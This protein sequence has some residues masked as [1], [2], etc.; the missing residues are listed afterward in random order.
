MNFQE[1]VRA[2]GVVPV[3][4][5]DSEESAL[6]LG[7]ILM[8]EGL[9]IMELTFRNPAAAG[10]IRAVRK[11]FPGM[12]LGAGTLRSPGQ[13]DAALDAGADFLVSPS[14]VPSVMSAWVK[15]RDSVS[16]GDALSLPPYIPGV[17]TP[18]EVEEAL[19][20]GLSFLKFFPAAASGGVAMLKAMKATHPEVS[21]MPTGGIGKD[22]LPDFMA[23][24]NVAACGASAV[25]P[26]DALNAG[27]F[28]AVRSAVSSYIRLIKSL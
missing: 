2:F 3:L 7:D 8:E 22:N 17:C 4:N 15:L 6:K 12:L 9:G 18:R 27:D 19:E 1:K 10:V 25:V 26:K 24:P 23:L 5:I 20:Y 11:R 13:L 28:A 14:I 21:F 16:S